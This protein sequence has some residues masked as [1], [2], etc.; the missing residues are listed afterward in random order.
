MILAAVHDAL[1]IETETLDLGV[2]EDQP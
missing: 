1:P 2:L